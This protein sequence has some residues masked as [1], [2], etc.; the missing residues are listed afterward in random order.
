M[1]IYIYIYTHISLL[2]SYFLF[3]FFKGQ[4]PLLPPGDGRTNGTDGLVLEEEYVKLYRK[5]TRKHI[6]YI[7]IYIHI[8][9][10]SS[11]FLGEEGGGPG[12]T[13]GR[14]GRY[15]ILSSEN[16]PFFGLG[17]GWDYF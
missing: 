12:G 2:L 11:F 8:C 5:N 3:L 6:T 14:T 9:F 7:Y 15:G 1:Y 16:P 10:S 13:D 4:S 17:D